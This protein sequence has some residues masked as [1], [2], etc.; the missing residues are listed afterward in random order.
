MPASLHVASYTAAD[1]ARFAA[2]LP[3][4]QRRLRGTPGL[5]AGHVF[6]TANFWPLTMGYPTLRRYALLTAFEDEGAIDEF[7][8]SEAARAFTGPALESWRLTLE[9]TTVMNGSWRGWRPSTDEV[10]PL[11]GDEPLAVMTYGVLRPRYAAKFAV[12]NR[13]VI[14]ASM[15]QEGQILR[16]ALFDRP[17]SVCTFS[18]WRSKGHAMRFAYGADTLHKSVIRPWLDTPW[19]VDN[20]FARFRIRDSVGTCGGLDPLADARPGPRVSEAAVP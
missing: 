12:W 8:G 9:P 16:L 15:N 2:R 5:V 10:A 3:R 1:A 7:E 11:T 14:A 13:R 19:G 20:F 17:L 6:A 18:V 4:L